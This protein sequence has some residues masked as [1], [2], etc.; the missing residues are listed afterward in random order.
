LRRR[1]IKPIFLALILLLP[2]IFATV[3][4]GANSQLNVYKLNAKGGI[5]GPNPKPPPDE[6]PT[7]GI[8]YELFIE[9]DYL[10]G[11]EP[12]VAVREYIQAYYYDRGINVIFQVVNVTLTVISLGVDYENGINDQEFRS[13]EAACNDHDY[14]YYSKW[15]WVLYGTTVEGAPDVVGYTWVVI[16]RRD[17]LAGNYIFIAYETADSW[18]SSK[19]IEP[20]G[21]EAVVLM[22]ELGH[23]IGIGKI[24]PLFG[25]IYDSDTYSVMS[26]LNLNNA[27]LYM[28]WYYSDEYWATRNMGYYKK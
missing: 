19:G 5:P 2:L 24:H 1:V 20:Y 13:I 28:D 7:P 27:G 16:F 12:T 18:A 4:T 6:E 11:H 22:H 21:A 8:E 9:I 10:G 3:S 23:S 15:K 25:E 26:Y 14:G 17:I